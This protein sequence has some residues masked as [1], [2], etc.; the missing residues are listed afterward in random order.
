MCTLSR[1][2]LFLKSFIQLFVP[3]SPTYSLSVRSAL[4]C[5]HLAD[6]LPPLNMMFR[7]KMAWRNFIIIDS[8]SLAVSSR[9]IRTREGP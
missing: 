8:L 5:L 4:Y 2:R 1:P 9:T 7:K 6:A 3:H